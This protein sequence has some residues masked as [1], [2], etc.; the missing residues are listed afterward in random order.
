MKL[1]ES[2]YGNVIVVAPTGHIDHT[3]ADGFED[4][5]MPYVEHCASGNGFLV[6]DLSQV[7]YMS[8]AGLRVLM[9]ADRKVADR[10]DAI[11]VAAMQPAMREIFEISRFHMIFKTFDSVRDALEALSQDALLAFEND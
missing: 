10:G 2:T 9:A 11:A 8:S 3:A 1:T 4:A 7:E 6:L 5:L